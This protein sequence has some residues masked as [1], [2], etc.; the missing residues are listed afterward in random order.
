M[1]ARFN[2]MDFGIFLLR[3]MVGSAVIGIH[4]G[5]GPITGSAVTD[6]V[7]I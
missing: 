7:D 4:L 2:A 6:I 5:H 3:V 1:T